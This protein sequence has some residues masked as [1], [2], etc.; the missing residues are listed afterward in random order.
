MQYSLEHILFLIFFCY[1]GAI[2]FNIGDADVFGKSDD[3]SVTVTPIRLLPIFGQNI[4][5]L[6]VSYRLFI[7]FKILGI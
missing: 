6:H 1:A 5:S 7:V 4:T 3:G 2:K